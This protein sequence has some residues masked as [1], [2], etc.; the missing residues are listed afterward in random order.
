[1][2]LLLSESMPVRSELDIIGA[3]GDST[4][5]YGKIKQNR[6]DGIGLGRV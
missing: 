1:M 2:L 3:A 5:L 6:S 4:R